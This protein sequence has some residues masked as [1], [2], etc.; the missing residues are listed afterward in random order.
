MCPCVPSHQEVSFCAK[1]LLS[2]PGAIT[3]PHKQHFSEET[4]LN[5]I[6]ENEAS[7]TEQQNSPG[8]C[9]WE[10]SEMPSVGALL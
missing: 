7:I 1:A 2:H 3:V 8:N 9:F 6:F 10:S 5:N 4:L